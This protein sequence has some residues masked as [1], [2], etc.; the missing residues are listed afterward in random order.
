MDE[1]ETYVLVAINLGL[2]VLG[3]ILFVVLAVWLYRK[4]KLLDKYF[5]GEIQVRSPPPA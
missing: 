5:A 4:Y 1:E 2:T 3:L